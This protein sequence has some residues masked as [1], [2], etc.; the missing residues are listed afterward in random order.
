MRILVCGGAGFIGSHLTDRLLAEGHSVDVVDNLTTGSLANL[1][2]A[3]ASGGDFKFHHID[4]E[5]PSFGDLVEA[6]RPEV[7]YQL[8]SLT[9]ESIQPVA[10]LRSMSSTLALL[11][12]AKRLDEPRVVMAVPAGLIYGEVPVKELPAK[13]SR[14]KNPFG[15]PGVIAKALLELLA[16]YRDSST[17]DYVA[18]AMTHVYGTRQRAED[19]VVASFLDCVLHERD[20]IV[21][22]SGKQSRDFL[23]IDDA[24]DA[25]ARAATRG[26]GTLIN[27]GT[28]K[29]TTIEKLWALIGEDST[30]SI[31][32]APARP[33]DLTRCSVS[34]VRAKI[35]L[36]WEPWTDLGSGITQVRA[37]NS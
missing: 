30:L 26:A 29:S 7:I 10:S 9:P 3:R 35:A 17:I 1:S 20:P 15:V 27:V 25:L 22:G 18:L 12:T 32:K 11:E 33:T 24:V 34:P 23:Y 21:F 37:I 16:M 14:T 28:A 5:H 6:R 8:T 4:V 19:G 2:E 36:G 13:E 31:R